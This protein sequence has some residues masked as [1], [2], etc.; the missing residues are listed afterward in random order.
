MKRPDYFCCDREPTNLSMNDMKKFVQMS[1]LYNAVKAQMKRKK[2]EQQ[3]IEEE[4]KRK[5]EEELEFQD[6]LSYLSSNQ[7]LNK[8]CD[9]F[10]AASIDQ[11][12]DATVLDSG[13]KEGLDKA[14]RIAHL[15]STTVDCRQ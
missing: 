8:A 1:R 2:V 11:I 6:M 5:S 9:D 13:G 12:L 3:Q 10:D 4:Q 14:L 15:F 7:F